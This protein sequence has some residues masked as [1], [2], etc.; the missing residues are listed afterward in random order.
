MGVDP[1]RG[2]RCRRPL[3]VRSHLK[4]IADVFSQGSTT[5]AQ[6]QQRQSQ[7]PTDVDALA[8]FLNFISSQRGKVRV[9]I[10]RHLF[11][12]VLRAHITRH[13]DKFVGNSAISNR[14][15]QRGAFNLHV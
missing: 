6:A 7:G 4:A 3:V 13:P 12:L 9:T 1:M 2:N 8:R 5:A 11:R 14:H 15:D 10:P